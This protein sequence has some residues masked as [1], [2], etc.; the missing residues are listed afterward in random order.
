MKETTVSILGTEY[1]FLL[2]TE[3]ENVKLRECSGL[4]EPETKKL[5]VFRELV[6]DV[7]IVEGI[8]D[9][10]KKVAR[11]EIVHAFFIESGLS[12]DFGNNEV[13]VDWIAIQM[14]KMIKAM[15]EVGCLD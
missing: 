7:M 4:T 10:R 14:P 1:E 8:D 13:L 9:Y 2:Q 3:Q 12:N 6:D 11:H 15:K 5:I